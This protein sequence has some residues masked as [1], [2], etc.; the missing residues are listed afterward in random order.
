MKLSVIGLGYLGAV[1]AVSMVELGHSVIGLDV[2]EYRVSQLSDGIAPFYEPRF[3]SLLQRGLDSGRLRFT[4]KYS[5]LEHVD[6]HF[7]GIGTPQRKDGLGSDLT[8]VDE[9]IESLAKILPQ[10]SGR[11]TLVVGKSTVPV[12]TSRKL[13]SLLDH[14]NDVHLIWN[15]EFL[16][17][18]LAVKDSLNPD[19]VIYGVGD[20]VSSKRAIKILDSV[21]CPI[22]ADGTPRLVV[23]YETAETIKFAANAFLAT[24]VSFINAIA[25]FCEASG[26]DVEEVSSAIGLDRR[27]GSEYL[28]AGVGFGGGCL[29]KDIRSFQASAEER[30]LSGVFGLLRQVDSINLGRRATYVEAAEEMLGGVKGQRVT[31]LGAAFKPDSDDTRDSPALDVAVRLIKLGAEVTITDPRALPNVDVK[32][33]VCEPELSRAL[34]GADLIMLL[35]DWP[36]YRALDPRHISTLVRDRKIIDG[37]N[38]LSMSDWRDAGWTI[39][40]PGRP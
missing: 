15:P 34:L 7:L 38:V 10:A 13:V 21:Y 35:T 28:R 16:R 20:R 5:D 6:V 30:G 23:S 22:L 36:E 25:E 8:H 14:L 9:A 32:G 33:A 3:T 11:E 4:T 39:R 1:H 31:V 27:I 37:R 17:E 18:G 29:P 40:A 24:K 19:R 26:G 12:G 2:D